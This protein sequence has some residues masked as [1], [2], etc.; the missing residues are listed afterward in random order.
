MFCL[1]SFVIP[2]SI[3][4]NEKNEKTYFNSSNMY[5]DI[6]S[7]RTD[8]NT[9]TQYLSNGNTNAPNISLSRIEGLE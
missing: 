4:K 5:A 1:F 3:I 8:N 9:T 6:F 2:K 7:K